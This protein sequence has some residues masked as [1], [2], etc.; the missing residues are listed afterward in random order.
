V[1][2]I[3]PIR[4][5]KQYKSLE[6]QE[7]YHFETGEPIAKIGQVNG[8]MVQMDMRKADNARKALRSLSTAELVDR[9][10]KAAHLFEHETLPLGDGIQTV[11]ILFT[12]SLPARDYPSTCVERTCKR[13]ASCSAISIEYWTH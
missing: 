10:K 3:N 7:V 5:G 11:M 8:G 6:F 13:I 12:N 9:C 1:L 2:T 4:W